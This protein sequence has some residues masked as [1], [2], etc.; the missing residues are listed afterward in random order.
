ML[1]YT[2]VIPT[3]TNTIISIIMKIVITLTTTGIIIFVDDTRIREI[4]LFATI[5]IKT[6]FLGCQ[7]QTNQYCH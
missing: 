6:L 5:G 2:A 7:Y 4:F 3:I 1:T